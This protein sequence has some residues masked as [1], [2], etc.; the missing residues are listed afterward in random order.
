MYS[1]QFENIVSLNDKSV[2]NSGCYLCVWHAHKIPPH[3]GLIIDSEYF[4]LKVKGKDSSLPIAEILKLIHRKEICTL[5][6]EIKIPITKA[7]IIAAF[8]QFS[9][10]EAY[11]YSCLTP[12]AD[13]FDLRQD[14][15]MLADL[16]NSF[17]SKDLIGNV[18][19]LN[20]ISDFKGI[21]M[22][23]KEE[24]EARLK[25]LSKTM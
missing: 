8:S 4:S 18:F 2:L 7:Q 20:L 19:G 11:K 25:A 17:K 13:I 9:N 15:S 22:Y 5:L 3:I 21:P 10:A 23:G 6:I 24:I 1:F 12:I 16:L 14:V